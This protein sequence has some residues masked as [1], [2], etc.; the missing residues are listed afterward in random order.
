MP[1]QPTKTLTA[2]VMGDALKEAVGWSQSLLGLL[3][4]GGLKL[5]YFRFIRE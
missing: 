2:Y 1:F 5:E 4:F 3:R